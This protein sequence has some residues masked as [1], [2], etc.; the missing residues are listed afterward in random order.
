MFSLFLFSFLL[1]NP[2]GV[3][4]IEG[5]KNLE[6]LNGICVLTTQWKGIPNAKE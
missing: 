3:I 5:S 1:H 4:P 2:F 6:T